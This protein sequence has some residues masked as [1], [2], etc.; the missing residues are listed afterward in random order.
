MQ[1]R[2]TVYYR[3]SS[4]GSL[5]D[6]AAEPRFSLEKPAG[7]LFSKVV[8]KSASQ[9]CLPPM[10]CE[11]LPAIAEALS[12]Q[13]SRLFRVPDYSE[14]RRVESQKEFGSAFAERTTR[15]NAAPTAA[16]R[17]LIR[18]RRV[19]TD[20]DHMKNG[21]STGYLKPSSVMV[22]DFNGRPI[23]Y[24]RR[25]IRSSD[26][27]L[28]QFC[29]GV[30]DYREISTYDQSVTLTATVS[31]SAP[32]PG[33]FVVLYDGAT[34]LE[35]S[36]L[37]GGKATFITTRLSSGDHPIAGRLKRTRERRLQHLAGPHPNGRTSRG[38]VPSDRKRGAGISGCL[39]PRALG[40]S[41]MQ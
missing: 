37:D 41:S 6:G 12:V 34:V 20:P 7:I 24:S 5:E 23:R 14:L 30:G 32:V 31:S 19:R 4:T 25:R 39:P 10:S 21:L 22:A 17:I 13:K 40:A 3:Q 29:P 38:Y 15:N 9:K 2:Q 27:A 26:G 33:S 18:V 35:S 16:G 11:T 8:S 1:F 36:F 28:E